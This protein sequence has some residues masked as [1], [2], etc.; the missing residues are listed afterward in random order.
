MFYDGPSP[1][2]GIFDQFLTI[3]HTSADISTRSFLLLVQSAPAN[4][5]AGTR[6][7][8]H[9]VSFLECSPEILDAISN[10]TTFWGTRLAFA[11]INVTYNVEPFLETIYT[12]N[13]SPTA[14][15]FYRT[16]RTMPLLFEYL[17]TLPTSDLIAHTAMRQSAEH[18][19]RVAVE[20]G[21]A[22]A[23][24]PLYPN[25]ALFGTPIERNYGSNRPRLRSIKAR[26][27]PDNVMGLV[28]GWKL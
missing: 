18:L 15:P 17:W 20:A 3:P 14:F 25:Y 19:T 28:G 21:Q 4:V 5:T 8:F 24:A 11:G 2:P 23:Q 26:V 1:P 6:G 22:V 27:D 10:E 13:P 7:G 12:H 16:P 9:A